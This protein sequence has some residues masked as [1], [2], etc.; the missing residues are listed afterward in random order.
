MNICCFNDS[1]TLK[2][3]LTARTILVLQVV[4]GGSIFHPNLPGPGFGSENLRFT[5]PQNQ[6]VWLVNGDPYIIWVVPPPRIPVANEG[7]VRDPL[8]KM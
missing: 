6:F 8:L 2:L 5:H 4:C 7:L 1:M 3:G